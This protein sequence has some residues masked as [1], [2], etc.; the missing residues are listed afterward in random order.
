MVALTKRV[1]RRSVSCHG[2]YVKSIQRIVAGLNEEEAS[3]VH[4]HV[5][6]LTY[7]QAPE[8]VH[9]V[10]D[11]LVRAADRQVSR[12]RYNRL[13]PMNLELAE[14]CSNCDGKGSYRTYRYL[15]SAEDSSRRV[16]GQHRQEVCDVCQ[17]EGFFIRRTEQEA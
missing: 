9:G 8:V 17:G 11:D 4:S 14:D 6:G 1:V 13:N 3:A 2:R 5:Y 16:M 10:G 15:P 7:L 12:E